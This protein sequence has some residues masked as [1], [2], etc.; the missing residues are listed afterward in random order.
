MAYPKVRCP[1][2]NMRGKILHLP[3]YPSIHKAM[4]TTTV[5]TFYLEMTDPAALRPALPPPANFTLVRAELP[6]P[7]LNRFLYTAVGGNWYWLNRLG[8]S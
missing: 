4:P 1:K 8:W 5:T 2:Y 6:S 7:E 3:S